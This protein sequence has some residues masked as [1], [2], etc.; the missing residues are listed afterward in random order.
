MEGPDPYNGGIHLRLTGNH[1]ILMSLRPPISRS[2][3]R[4][5]RG[6][7]LE[8]RRMMTAVDLTAREIMMVELINRARADPLA[9]AARYGIDLNEGLDPGTISPE[10]K[11][12]L[13]PHQLLTDAAR[14]HA[15]DMLDRNF[16]AHDNLDGHDPSDRAMAAGYPAGAGENIAWHGQSGPRMTSEERSQQVFQQ[17]EGLFLS[18]GHRKNTLR[19]EFREVGVGIEFGSFTHNDGVDYDSIMVAQSFGNRGGH[20]FITGVVFNDR[21]IA[22]NFYT[23]GE[24]VTNVT[25]TAERNGDPDFEPQSVTTQPA[26]SYSLQVPNGTYKLTATGGGV[27]EIVVSNIVV[28]GSNVKLDFN[29]RELEINEIAGSVFQDRNANGLH[30]NND[31]RLSGQA[32]F[33]DA[34]GDRQRDADETTVFTDQD[35]NFEFVGLLT[36]DYEVVVEIPSGWQVTGAAGNAK[37]VTLTDRSSIGH[38]FAL[39]SPN[40]RPVAVDDDYLIDQG[41]RPTFDILANDRD[42]DGTIDTDTFTLVTAPK[43]GVLSFEDGRASYTPQKSFTGTDE[44][45]YEVRDNRGDVSGIAT[46]T[47]TIGNQPRTSFQNHLNIYD[48]DRNGSVNPLDAL[49]VRND[50]TAFNPRKLPAS[51]SDA[52]QTRWIDVNGDGFVSSIDILEVLVAVQDSVLMREAIRS[53]QSTAGGVSFFASAS[54]SIDRVFMEIGGLHDLSHDKRREPSI[55]SMDIMDVILSSM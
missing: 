34:D 2:G 52:P 37:T 11:Q 51:R 55:V 39:H 16:F 22:D 32:V 43:R 15:L 25:I 5:L 42:N 9:E 46:V 19:P 38:V 45:Q 20:V 54:A 47:I 26:G 6:E 1:A 14:L 48:V 36:G 27:G 40:D 41:A 7:C 30:D 10:P 21:R 49:V 44:F 50:I 53:Q 8:D 17:H 28:E 31:S 18:E 4:L 35:G 23:F 29:L 24:G 13:A 3:P 33:L 12:P